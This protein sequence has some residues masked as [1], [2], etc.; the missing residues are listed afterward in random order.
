[1]GFGT[2]HENR[3]VDFRVE[4]GKVTVGVRDA[5][6]GI[7]VVGNYVDANDYLEHS[8]FY[9][10]DTYGNALDYSED[11]SNTVK[12]NA[13]GEKEYNHEADPVFLKKWVTVKDYDKYT[14]KEVWDK[15]LNQYV[16]ERIYQTHKELRSNLSMKV[17]WLR[18]CV[19][20]LKQE[21]Q[22]LKYEIAKLKNAVGID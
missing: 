18:Q 15:V 3:R 10:K 17:A 13:Q 5:N 21:N 7:L 12:L 11:C 19:F 16:T 22:T 8:S 9:D 14:E 2:D 20:E 6:E 4:S 1:V